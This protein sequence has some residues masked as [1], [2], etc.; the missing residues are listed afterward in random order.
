MDTTLTKQDKALPPKDETPEG[1][2]TTP[3]STE[4]PPEG[5]SQT[6]TKVEIEK[7]VQYAL[8]KAG[9]DWKGLE[10]ERDTLK[11]QILEKVTELEDIQAERESLTKQVDDLA[12]GDPDRFDLI[13][14]GRELRER[15]RKYEADLKALEA[16]KQKHGERLTQAEEMEREGTILEVAFDYEGADPIKLSELCEYFKASTEEQIRK[17][18]DTLW[19]KKGG[20]PPITIDSG[21][22]SGGGE[23]SEKE[24]LKRRY[25]KMDIK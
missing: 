12:S 2:G 22:T 24:R 13:K 20:T 6:Y 3:A 5:T 1:K 15:E 19:A 8:M 10:T 16:D 9:R 21:I 11:A 14:K 18:A 4:T 7:A 17:V 25:P 23:L